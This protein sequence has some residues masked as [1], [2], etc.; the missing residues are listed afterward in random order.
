MTL[1]RL[2][3]MVLLAG[4]GCL[5]AVG[6][7]WRPAGDAVQTRATA[8]AADRVA[9]L[10]V[11]AAWDRSRAEAWRR[12][13]PAA[14]APL[15]AAGSVAGRA[16]RSLLAA[17]AGRGLRVTG[18]T[19][20]RAEVRV[21]AATDDRLTLVVTDRL[22]GGTAIAA[23]DRVPLPRDGW[24]TRTVVLARAGGE[25]RVADV[26]DQARPVAST[27]VTSRSANS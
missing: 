13:D 15:Y 16:D 8:P 2:L 17:Y 24:S 14:L 4:L 12:G 20:Q 19:V 27:D 11:L 22:V 9:P 18:L 10:A 6:V 21:V 3:S 25:W 26:R 1:T 5:L 7:A 23:G